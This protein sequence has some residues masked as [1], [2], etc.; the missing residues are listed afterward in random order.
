MTGHS[1]WT[2]YDPT[3]A[4]TWTFERNPREMT[5]P[6]LPNQTTGMSTTVDLLTR[7]ERRHPVPVEW[8]FTG[9]IRSQTQHDALR[10]WATKDH[11]V[12]VKD[13]HDRVFEVMFIQFDAQEQ[14][15]T[16]RIP[17]RFTYRMRALLYRRVS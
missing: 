6:H 10:T 5:T 1:R 3:L 12:H 14:R 11:R 16:A 17:W 13:H 7:V 9:D 4:T 2:L 8:T 15:P